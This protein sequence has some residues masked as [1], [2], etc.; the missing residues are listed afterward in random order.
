MSDSSGSESDDDILN[1]SIFTKKPDRRSERAEKQKMD[2]LD[3][4]LESTNARTDVQRRIADV[5]REQQQW[6]VKEEALVKEEDESG[7]SKDDAIGGVGLNT[8]NDKEN[9]TNHAAVK[10]EVNVKVEPSADT[11]TTPSTSN[12]QSKRSL[13]DDN[14]ESY[15]ERVEN[16]AKTNST[17]QKNGDI[18]TTR[19][20]LADAMNGLDYDSETDDEDGK[21]VN[22]SSGMTREQ[23]RSE[24][25]AKMTGGQSLLG[26]R[27]M[28]LPVD[29]ARETKLAVGS[30]NR[31]TAPKKVE[32]S[33]GLGYYLFDSRDEAKSELK[34]IM[35]ELEKSHRKTTTQAQTVLREDFIDPLNKLI[36]K[37]PQDLFWSS[38]TFFL[39][40]NPVITFRSK[41]TCAVA[42]PET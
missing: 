26:L 19:R 5:E 25:A 39:R 10:L 9:I 31:N 36:K 20:K 7:D 3:Q 17:K 11:A 32:A 27:R 21:W 40:H 42:I 22:G 38:M 16:F 1:S 30:R 29:K 33:D 34:S 15:W 14:D 12:Q 35:S 13:I 8:N 4:C 23:K 24:A 28:F 2:F 6:L 41:H 18:N 37:C